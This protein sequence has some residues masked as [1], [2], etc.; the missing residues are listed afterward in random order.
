MES[1]EEFEQRRKAAAESGLVH[2]AFSA[3]GDESADDSRSL[4]AKKEQERTEL[5]MAAVELLLISEAANS[6][7]T[8]TTFKEAMNSEESDKWHAAMKKEMDSCEQKRHGFESRG[9]ICL[10]IQTFS[11]ASGFT[12]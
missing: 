10:R 4:S 3:I 2:M 6:R 9:V 12:S 5:I 1:V 8:P 11:L 7:F